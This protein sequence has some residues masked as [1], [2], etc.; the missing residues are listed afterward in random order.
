M[1]RFHIAIAVKEINESI[2][3]YNQKLG[4]E[5]EVVIAG[6][7]ALWRTEILNLSIR[8]T[9]DQAERPIRH[10]GW[11]DPMATSFTSETDINGV[12]WECFSQTDQHDE[13][14]AIWP[15]TQFKT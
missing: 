13:I 1:K 7:Y 15:E 2:T 12:H 4:C 10:I 5:P 14:L 9:P 3:L 6:E 11:E 8:L